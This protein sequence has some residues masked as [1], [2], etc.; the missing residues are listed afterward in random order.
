MPRPKKECKIFDLCVKHS[1]LTPDIEY[2]R[3][4]FL[5]P[6]ELQAIKLKDIEKL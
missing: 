6:E 1:S 2:D 3:T 4:I 5:Y